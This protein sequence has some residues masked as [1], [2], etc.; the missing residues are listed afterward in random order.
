MERWT[1]RLFDNNGKRHEY[2]VGAYDAEQAAQEAMR[3][4]LNDVEYLDMME[5]GDER[6]VA[7]ANDDDGFVVEDTGFVRVTAYLDIK[8]STEEMDADDIES[9]VQDL[10]KFLTE[11]Q[12]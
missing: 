9:E 2:K 8:H 11:D 4:Y 10:H 3:L 1:A 5:D 6:I 12:G 7:V